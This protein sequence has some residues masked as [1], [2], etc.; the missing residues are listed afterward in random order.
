MQ[1]KQEILFN[2]LL[3]FFE[4]ERSMKILSNILIDNHLS[5]RLIDYFVTSYS[6]IFNIG[7]RIGDSVFNVFVGYKSILKGYNKKYF[8]VFCRRERVTIFSHTHKRSIETTV[9]QLHFFSWAIR[10]NIFQYIQQ[11]AREIEEHMIAS[12]QRKKMP[13][14]DERKKVT[15]KASNQKG[16]TATHAVQLRLSF[17]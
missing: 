9:G 14:G 11:H 8:D 3:Q 17:E 15:I 1:T 6:K 4:D 10:Y 5:L 12:L 2:S 16:V 7:Y 13:S